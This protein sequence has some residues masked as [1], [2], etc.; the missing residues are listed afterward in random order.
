[1]VHHPITLK[2]HT[3]TTEM[4]GPKNEPWQVEL[5]DPAISVMTDFRLRAMFKI[6]IDETIDEALHK[7]KI[8]ALRMAFVTEKG[9]ENILGAITSYDIMGEKP[10]RFLQSVGFSDRAITHKDIR[11]RDIMEPT[12]DW[13]VTEMQNVDKVNVQSVL[14]ALQK[15]GRTHIPVIECKEGETPRLRGL[16]SA[17][18]VLRLT[19]FS[20]QKIAKK[21]ESQSLP[22]QQAKGA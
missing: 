9:S 22:T 8:A 15:T 11:V 20:R 10:M 12:K 3:N 17:S 7:M 2:T 19:E 13:V 16:F 1:M 21:L 4:L 14:E 18:M 6:D 5:K